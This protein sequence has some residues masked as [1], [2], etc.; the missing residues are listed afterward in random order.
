[1]GIKNPRQLPDGGFYLGGLKKNSQNFL[2]DCSA[3]NFT[4]LVH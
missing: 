4:I 3:I 1:M 2:S